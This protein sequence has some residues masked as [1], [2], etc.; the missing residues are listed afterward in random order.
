MEK[1]E[2]IIMARA[3]AYISWAKMKMR[4]D[5]PNHAAYPWYGGKGI[6]YDPFWCDYKNFH[7]DMGD[8]TFSQ[9]LDRIDN[10]KNYCKENC[11]WVSATESSQTTSRVRLNK[12]KVKQIRALLRSI[13]PGTPQIKAHNLIAEAFKVTRSMI[14]L[15]ATGRN[16]SNVK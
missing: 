12:E 15:I 5:N 9:V 4:C 13:K 16:W 6:S 2:W 11:R 1:K 10:T 8:R 3:P 7:A 14:Y